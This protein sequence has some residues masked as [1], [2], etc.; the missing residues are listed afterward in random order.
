[1]KIREAKES[2]INEIYSLGKDVEE[3]ST[4]DEVVTFWPKYIL[5]NCIKSKT[6]FLLIAEENNRIA[7]FTITNYNPTFKKA[8]L[9]N[10]YV[11][12]D[13]R[14]RKIGRKL[15]ESVIEKLKRIDCEY[16]CGLT[17]TTN[18]KVIELHLELGFNEGKK[19]IWLDKILNKKFSKNV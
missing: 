1:M 11:H 6:D 3:F 13:F 18:K 7:G 16:I 9:E 4:T 2:D 5:E 10:L 12:P 19:Y 14:D 8:M 15:L 17:E